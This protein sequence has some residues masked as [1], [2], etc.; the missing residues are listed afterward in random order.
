MLKQVKNTALAF[1]LSIACGAIKMANEKCLP[2]PCER[3]CYRE[4]IFFSIAALP[5]Q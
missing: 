3:M 1:T 5:E 4:C 2:W